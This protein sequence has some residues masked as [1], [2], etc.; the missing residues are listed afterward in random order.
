M[1]LEKTNPVILPI[2]SVGAKIPPTPP[3]PNVVVTATA[4]NITTAIKN[5]ITKKALSLIEEK[6]LLAKREP[7]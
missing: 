1:L 7:G 3:A 5:I 6:G 2:N 4:L